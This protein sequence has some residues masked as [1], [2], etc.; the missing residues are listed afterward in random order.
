MLRPALSQPPAKEMS[1]E[2]SLLVQA[3]PNSFSRLSTLSSEQSRVLARHLKM[4][5]ELSLL[6]LTDWIRQGSLPKPRHP[7]IFW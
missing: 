5:A 6:L 2:E 4:V 7:D 1:S 3:S